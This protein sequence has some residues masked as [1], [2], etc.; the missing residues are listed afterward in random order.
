MDAR[1]SRAYKPAMLYLN[2][3]VSKFLAVIA[4]FF[5]LTF[6]AV[7][8]VFIILTVYD[9]DVINVEHVFTIISVTGAVAG[10]ARS[11]I[12]DEVI[13]IKSNLTN[14]DSNRI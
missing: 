7:F 14:K 6:G 3:F 2:S 10:I 1:L 8:A 11:L 9:E 13:F 5:V 4:K 12:P